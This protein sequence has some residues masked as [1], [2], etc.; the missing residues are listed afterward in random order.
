MS[1]FRKAGD[2]ESELKP[3]EHYPIYQW[4]GI[5]EHWDP[6]HL[7]WRLERTRDPKERREIEKLLRKRGIRASTDRLAYL[8]GLL[9]A[10]KVASASWQEGQIIEAVR[11]LKW[12]GDVEVEK[13]DQFRVLR[14]DGREIHA[15]RVD[16]TGWHK[17]NYFYLEPDEVKL[18]RASANAERVAKKW[19]SLPKGW[20]E[21]SV[22]KFWHSL[23][24]RAP[25]HPVTRCIN[26]M[27]GKVSN[28][29]A[30]CGGL[31][32]QMIPGWR[33][34]AAKDKKASSKPGPGWSPYTKYVWH[35]KDGSHDVWWISD[36][37]DVPEAFEDIS[38]A[39]DHEISR[40]RVEPS[41]M[42]SLLLALNDVREWRPAG[43][44][45][46]GGFVTSTLPGRWASSP[47]K[48]K[49]A[50]RPP[51]EIQDLIRKLKALGVRTEGD[52]E[53]GDWAWDGD[54]KLPVWAWD[55]R[56]DGDRFEVFVPDKKYHDADWKRQE[57][58]I[59]NLFAAFAKANKAKWRF[60]VDPYS[61]GSFFLKERVTK[62]E[63]EDRRQK[64]L[65]DLLKKAK[66]GPTTFSAYQKKLSK[67]F[68]GV[69]WLPNYLADALA[70][71]SHGRA[72]WGSWEAIEDSEGDMRRNKRM[73]AED[74]SEPWHHRNAEYITDGIIAVVDW[75][76]N[77]WNFGPG[78]AP[79]KEKIPAF[80]RILNFI[81]NKKSAS[82]GSR[83]A[84][85]PLRTQPDYGDEDDTSA[86]VP[87]GTSAS[88]VAARY[89]DPPSRSEVIT[90]LKQAQRGDRYKFDKGPGHVYGGT[91]YEKI[92]DGR[93]GRWLM[94]YGQTGRLPDWERHPEYLKP[95][96]D[97]LDELKY[98]FDFYR[99]R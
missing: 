4:R 34:E 20:T 82:D 73:Y 85:S 75:H 46:D 16:D 53:L 40:R 98:S 77:A 61:D 55:D 96:E 88:R 79:P 78:E 89:A 6:D 27:E 24:D 50:P 70:D 63:S 12:K 2:P 41:W 64:L 10:P 86:A 30:F 56:L 92:E 14:W 69:R 44:E 67:L 18:V 43:H 23:T 8:E 71:E 68:K 93:D 97:L 51:R 11:D 52:K 91:E 74:L 37:K 87:R 38:R 94:V 54:L 47:R 48:K 25:K 90:Q 3:S 49:A 21:E 33:E 17:D 66:W 95:P 57:K 76:N 99:T 7:Q 19:K 15:E 35:K 83:Y 31:A 60:E 5:P 13:G 1:D 58:Q 42:N 26:E 22:E 29:G 45:A 32:D 28:P 80:D 81:Y 62:E 84:S 72:L 65:D 36:V 9:R 59:Y 39:I